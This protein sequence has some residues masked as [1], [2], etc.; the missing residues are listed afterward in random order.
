MDGATPTFD[1]S[2]RRP[3]ELRIRDL[4]D[5]GGISEDEARRLAGDRLPADALYVVRALIDPDH[6]TLQQYSIV[7]GADNA[8]MGVEML[9]NMWVA[10]G[11][12]LVRVGAGEGEGEEVARKRRFVQAVLYKLK[13][14]VAFLGL[15]DGLSPEEAVAKADD[16]VPSGVPSP[17]APPPA[18]G[19]PS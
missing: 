1:R 7:G 11:G 6:T 14:D 10:L 18:E 5:E 3:L 2:R 8:E 4:R 9:F 17:L 19:E 15:A 16:L 13:L 12:H